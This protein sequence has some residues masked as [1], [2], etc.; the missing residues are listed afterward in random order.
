MHTDRNYYTAGG[1]IFFKVYLTNEDLKLKETASKVL[2]V[3]LI[4][5]EQQ[6]IDSKI[7]SIENGIGRGDV[8]LSSR[9]E[10]DQYLLRAY[11]AFMKNNDPTFFFRKSIYINGIIKTDTNKIT[12][13]TP[14]KNQILFFP[15]GGDLLLGLS[16]RI[17][18]K[19]IGTNGLGIAVKAKIVDQTER[20]I[21]RFSTDEHGFGSFEFTPQANT[22][23]FA[24][25]EG[26]PKIQLQQALSEGMGLRIEVDEMQIDLTI[27]NSANFD[28]YNNGILVAHTR[29]KVVFEKRLIETKNYQLNLKKH[30]LPTGIIHFTLFDGL[31]RPQAERLVFNQVGSDNFNVDFTTNKEQYGKRE[32]VKLR[33]ELYDDEGEFL[34]AELSVSVVDHFLANTISTQPDIRTYL[35]LSADLADFVENPNR[36]LGSTNADL[37]QATDLLM[38]THAWRRFRWKDMLQNPTKTLKFKAEKGLSISGTVTP[39]KKPQKAVKA[40]GFISNFSADFSMTEFETDEEGYFR[41]DGLPFKDSTDI[42][43]Q[44]AIPKNKSKPLPVVAN[45]EE[46]KLKGDRNVDIQINE[47]LSYPSTQADFTQ[48]DKVTFDKK[49][50]VQLQSLE[51]TK[52]AESEDFEFSV[53]L[54]EVVV[55]E[56]KVDKVI[57]YYEDRM[58]YRRPNTR[59]GAA[60]LPNIGQYRDIYD[61][62]RGRVLGMK[63]DAP[64]ETL[65]DVGNSRYSIILRGYNTGLNSRDRMSNAAKFMVN[66][67]FVSTS[68]AEAINPMN[69]AFVDVVSSVNE[70]SLYGELGSNGLVMIYLKP[71]VQR[72][73]ENAKIKAPGILSLLYNGYDEAREFYRPTYPTAASD[74]TQLDTRVTLHWSPLL[75]TNEFGE[76]YLEFY[77]ADRSTIYDIIVEG[78]SEKGVPI[79][80]RT[81]LEVE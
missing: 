44:A 3:D 52:Q 48:F 4:D 76:V 9:L 68:Y 28:H 19:T 33:L 37:I 78:I 13:N 63:L 62:L 81:S 41:V 14:I 51:E 57:E 49:I 65:E 55:T 16:S 34:P 72:Q 43:I 80:A 60:E 77:T 69:I 26:T 35:L 46:I 42:I 73:I 20:E 74:A 25:V 18:V 30:A 59:I 32:R 50:G 40:Y 5:G 45:E 11:T 21:T 6:I 12:Q 58:L 15:E 64:E 79:I 75:K 56:G 39:Q 17:A 71:P 66:G 24:I 27:S 29:G 22:Q 2:Y 70:L 7:I 47:I 31:G 36:Y 54:G 53:E 67:A 61:I 8:K 10:N 1:D 38:M 23:Y